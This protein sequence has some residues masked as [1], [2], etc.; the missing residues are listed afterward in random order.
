MCNDKMTLEAVVFGID[1]APVGSPDLTVVAVTGRA[2]TSPEDPEVTYF[3]TRDGLRLI[4]R[5][6]R[7]AGFYTPGLSETLDSGRLEGQA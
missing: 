2:M 5:D 1:L 4:F 6:G 3:E 7:Y